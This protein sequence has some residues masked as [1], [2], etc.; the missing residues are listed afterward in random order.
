[1]SLHSLFLCIYVSDN[2]LFAHMLQ[3]IFQRVA[4]MLV[5]QTALH[6]ADVRLADGCI[7]GKSMDAPETNV[8]AAMMTSS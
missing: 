4:H 3:H 2:A 5:C 6:V 7:G 8:P 1:M